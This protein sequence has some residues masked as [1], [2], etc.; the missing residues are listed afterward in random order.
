M[1]G[2]ER[3]AKEVGSGGGKSKMRSVLG[4]LLVGGHS[5]VFPV[6]PPWTLCHPLAGLHLGSHGDSDVEG[7]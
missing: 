5:V 1:G 4:T 7:G 3:G 2:K 6:D